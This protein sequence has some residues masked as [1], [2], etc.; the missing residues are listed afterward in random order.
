MD[1]RLSMDD[2][3]RQ[4]KDVRRLYYRRALQTEKFEKGQVD[5]QEF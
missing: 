5:W 3:S 2:F 4:Y 1:G